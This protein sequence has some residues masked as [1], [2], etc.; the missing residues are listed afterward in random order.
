MA[1]PAAVFIVLFVMNSPRA[2][3]FGTGGR[4]SL[5]LPYLAASL[6]AALVS[7]RGGA[8]TVSIEGRSYWFLAAAPLSNKR[9]LAGK[10]VTAFCIGVVFTLLGS[11]AVSIFSGS[12]L[13]GLLLGLVAGIVGSAIV[14]LYAVG[15]SALFPRFDW[16]N[17]NQASSPVVGVLFLVCLAG[18]VV[19]TGLAVALALFV[20]GFLPL[21][22]S[23]AGAVLLW[24]ACAALP[25][26]ALYAAG[27]ERP[28]RLDW[29]L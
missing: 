15:V 21:W 1:W 4:F 13:P 27:A 20:S 6:L 11:L 23:I 22:A 7:F 16:E 18:F 26:Y 19:L 5:L 29:E 3:A 25:G 8:Q 24:L 12:Y 17:P 9:L 28:E 14:S 10:W 2:A